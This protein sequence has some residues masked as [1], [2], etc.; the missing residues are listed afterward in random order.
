[1]TDSGGETEL[2]LVEVSAPSGSAAA[3]A[4]KA[5]FGKI[6]QPQQQVLLYS[7]EEWEEFTREWVHFQKQKYHQVLRF[8]GANDMG[9]DVAGL[10]DEKGL[11]GVWDNFQCKHYGAP[12]APSTALAEIA[13]VL[14]HSYKKEYA[15][16]RKHYF[17]A[18]RDCGMMLKQMLTK[19]GELKNHVIAN[20]DKQ[21]ANAVTSKLT[22][23]LEGEFKNYVE[24]FDFSIFTMRTTLEII[25]EHRQTPYYVT[26]FGGGLPDRPKPEKPPIEVHKS[27]SRYMCQLFEAYGDHKK[28]DITDI[29]EL[30][31]WPELAEHFHR[32]R[33]F[34]YHAEALRNFARDTVPPSTFEDLQT[35]LHAGVIDVEAA[36]HVDGLARANAVTLAASSLQLTSNTLIGVVKIQDRKG[37]CHQ[38]ANENR[39]RWKKP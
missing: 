31:P 3:T 18:P 8:A 37:I 27:E 17:I 12:I 15:A 4:A 29:T 33:E 34:F 23:S 1:M 20:W 7:A 26:R 28:A 36:E 14:W 19:P 25:D 21:C 9:I 24:T 39:L 38:L 35:E 10:T 6:F 32:Q 2:S 5:Q 11:L 13:K 16:P 30:G 22:I